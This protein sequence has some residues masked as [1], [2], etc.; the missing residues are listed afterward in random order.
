MEENLKDKP[1]S[2]L[3]P[4]GAGITI[5]PVSPGASQPTT[6]L[7]RV[8]MPMPPPFTPLP[9]ASPKEKREIASL[10]LLL[11]VILNIFCLGLLLTIGIGKIPGFLA[12]FF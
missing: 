9:K 11:S 1:G 8:A 4:G 5:T 3:R 10:L 12:K 6:P 2:P 7:P